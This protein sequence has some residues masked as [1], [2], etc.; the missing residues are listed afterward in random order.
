MI[1][2]VLDRRPLPT[3]AFFLVPDGDDQPEPWE[4]IWCDVWSHH[5]RQERRQIKPDL[6][7]EG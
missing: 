7:G 5:Y 1:Y 6:G 4:K 3:G 2:V